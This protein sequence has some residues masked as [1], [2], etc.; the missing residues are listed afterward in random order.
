MAGALRLIGYWDGPGIEDGLPDVCEF[1]DAG[2]DLD[3]QRAV[4]TYLRSGTCFVATAG[5][6]VCRL[7]GV[8]N[9]T[10]ELTDGEHFVWP[11]GLAHYVEEHGV[12]LPEEVVAV[13]VR[14]PAPVVAEDL[15]EG[16]DVVIDTEW[17]SGRGG[18]A[19]RH[20]PGCGRSGTTAAWN[21]PAVAD[22][23]VDGVPPG[24]VAVLVQL[25]KLLSTAWP[26]SGL[27]DLLGA[28]PVLAV[29]G[30]APAELDRVL[31]AYPELRPYLFFGTEGG[32]VPLSS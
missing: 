25:R 20:F 23:Y 24:S 16:G 11:E 26:Y 1:V 27:R 3:V 10:T 30:G 18:A 29:G 5:W 31:V 15:L 21:L 8:A 28:Q 4:A 7:C 6:S 32:L 14:G 13:A 2:V 12:V 17:W 22:I 9:G 19:A